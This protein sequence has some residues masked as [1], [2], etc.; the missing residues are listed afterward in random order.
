VKNTEITNEIC[1]SGIWCPFSIYDIVMT[2]DIEAEPFCPSAKLIQTPLRV[3]DL[4]DPILCFAESVSQGVFE[5]AKP[6]IKLD[7]T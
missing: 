3:I 7:D 2:V 5:G 6:W 1:F 4:G